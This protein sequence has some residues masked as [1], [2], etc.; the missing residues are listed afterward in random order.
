MFDFGKQ[1]RNHL[2]Q[3]LPLALGLGSSL[4]G[5]GVIYLQE[6]LFDVEKL[7]RPLKERV[8]C[9]R[10]LGKIEIADA[11]VAART[12]GEN[13]WVLEFREITPFRFDD[14]IRLAPFRR[15]DVVGLTVPTGIGKRGFHGFGGRFPGVE[16]AIDREGRFRVEIDVTVST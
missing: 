10:R 11:H 15:F 3:N 7:H 14:V 2:Q 12:I 16:H 8:R 1:C 9:V 6:K 5:R 4:L 13:Q